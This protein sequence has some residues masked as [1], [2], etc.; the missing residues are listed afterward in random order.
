MSQRRTSSESS[1]IPDTRAETS[2]AQFP[3][4]RLHC[5]RS[6][7]PLGKQSHCERERAHHTLLCHQPARLGQS[8]V[9]FLAFRTLDS[10][11]IS[12]LGEYFARNSF[13]PYFDTRRFGVNRAV[14]G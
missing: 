9:R 4:R 12:R 13:D 14:A 3:P 5:R 10:E 8:S 7:A 6:E 11:L 2:P 1:P